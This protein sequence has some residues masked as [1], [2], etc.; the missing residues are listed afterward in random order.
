[1]KLI[2]ILITCL[3][4]GFVVNAQDDHTKLLFELAAKSKNW[5]E[6]FQTN[7]GK[8]EF[9]YHSFRNDVS[10]SMITRCKDGKMAIEWETELVPEDWTEN[11]AGVLWI[12]AFDLTPENL[13]FDVFING[14]K[15]F[16]IPT[17]TQKNWKIKSGD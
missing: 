5:F 13:V 7:I 2:F 1:M 12:A 6:G 9:S 14:I 3:F 10:K 16:E 4:S 8:N 15:R 11:E 17:T